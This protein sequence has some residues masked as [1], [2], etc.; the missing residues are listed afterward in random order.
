MRH[1]YD[2]LTGEHDPWLVVLAGTIC[3][4]SSLTAV[5]LITRSR[6]ARTRRS[7]KSWL[8][9]AAVAT[10]F[11][12]WATHFIAMLAYQPGL[13]LGYDLWLT[14][15]SAAIAIA[16][17]G[18]GIGI[19]VSQSTSRSALLG[20]GIVGAGI[21]SMHY[22]GMAAVRV[23]GYLEYDPAIV[24]SSVVLGIGLGTLAF[25]AMDH[26]RNVKGM[27]I[28]TVVLVLAI[29]TMHFSAMGSV[30]VIPLADAA[31]P[32]FLMSQHWLA[33]GIAAATVTITILCLSSSLFDQHL[34]RR[35]LAESTRLETL[36]NASTEG[37]VICTGERIE[38]GNTAFLEMT[39]SDPE[40]LAGETIRRFID[41]AS[42]VR[43]AASVET[44]QDSTFET[45]LITG[46]GD[47]VPVA[48]LARRLQRGRQDKMVLVLRDLTE[49]KRSQARIEYLA[50]HDALTGLANRA[51]FN[52]RLEHA[53]ARATRG[54]EGLAVLCIDLDRFKEVND[55]LG[56]AAGD[57]LL[58]AVATRIST[59]IRNTDTVAR[60]SGDEFAVVQVGSSQPDGAQRL[61][62]RLCDAIGGA[63][64]LKEGGAN[65]G[66]SIGV[67]IFPDDGSSADALLR[68]ADT[69]LYRAKAE[70]RNTY[71]FFEPDMDQAMR[72]RRELERDLRK[73]I[74]NGE[75]Y[76]EY[77]PQADTVTGNVVGLEALVRWEHPTRGSLP[78][79]E[80]IGLAEE[81]GF[82][83]QLGAWVLRQACTDAAG[84]TQ[85]I[86]VAVNLSP[87]QFQKGNLSEQV[88]AVLAETGLAA[89]RLELEITEGVLLS[90][91]DRA[92][93]ILSALKAQGV[94]IA[95]DDFGTGYSSLS[96]LQSFPFDKIKID[97]SFVAGLQGSDDARAI[98]K[99]VIGL[100]HALNL[101][102]VAEG[103]EDSFQLELLRQELCTEVQGFLIGRPQR[104]DTLKNLTGA[105][106]RSAATPR[107]GT[108]RH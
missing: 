75:L 3:F 62:E 101:P 100:S 98:V 37:I 41:D 71:R 55:T 16:V 25:K 38:Y 68:N 4:L 58:K 42:F 13:P 33:I 73:S 45:T 7:Q 51:Q 78:P 35:T 102:V 21:A 108:D 93:A 94:S 18:V 54:D 92:I 28:A 70:G 36:T 67:A 1:I 27:S 12:I 74:G 96:Y 56:H 86:K 34:V 53:L 106:P 31:M 5:S 52:D 40:A 20:G 79:Y 23:P 107:T 80:F 87:I 89:E 72:E 47:P 30:T 61:A 49:Q 69:A 85:P 60:L 76:L 81:C 84:W 19:Y 39:G 105:S 95:M 99:A 9:T 29:C 11:G 64:E 15:A 10:G 17:T 65:V 43:A 91:K 104:I 63:Y 6:D 90:D 88:A 83:I 59:E 46:S 26:W 97:R 50:H 32:E 82:I 8:A 103:V 77:Q 14:I 24:A 22:T 44:S 48:L 66:A 57:E 2:C